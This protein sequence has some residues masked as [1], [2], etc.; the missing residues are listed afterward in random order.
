MDP[1]SPEFSYEIE[2]T[3]Q[4]ASSQTSL[5]IVAF[6]AL[7]CFYFVLSMVSIYRLCTFEVNSAI[8]PGEP[9]ILRTFVIYITAACCFRLL[10]WLLCTGFFFTNNKNYIK[11][12][13][14]EQIKR[15]TIEA[16]AQNE[17]HWLPLEPEEISGINE[18]PVMLVMAIF[19]PEVFVLIAYLALCW[20]CFSVYIDSHSQ[21]MNDKVSQSNGR[22]MFLSVVSILMI[23]QVILVTLYLAGAITAKFILIELQSIELM[24]PIIVIVLILYYQCKFS[25]VPQQRYSE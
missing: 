18:S 2:V 20:L 17:T 6:F 4:T 11:Y 23:V 9:N 15:L 10:G 14:Y 24:F 7:S 25:G 8:K 3:M 1:E 16:N 22:I 12:A 21:G 13:T 5:L 19:T